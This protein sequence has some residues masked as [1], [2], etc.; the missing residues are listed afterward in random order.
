MS[1]S[2]VMEKANKLGITLELSDGKVRYSP[3]SKAPP[4]FIEM[5]RDNKEEII[6]LLHRKTYRPRFPK[7]TSPD[8]EYEEL[9]RQVEENGVVLLWSRVL[10]DFVAFYA[11]DAD[12]AKVPPG[13]VAYSDKELRILFTEDVP[14][15]SLRR[16]HEAKRSGADITGAWKE[17]GANF[18]YGNGVE[19]RLNQAS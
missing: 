4:D 10:K 5:L 16:I 2:E 8:V 15:R 17:T 1:A 19:V 11:T 9:V 3:A 12:R 14:P 13:F 18:P 7:G 6:G